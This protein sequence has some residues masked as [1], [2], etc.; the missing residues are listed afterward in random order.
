MR[1]LLL[2][3]VFG[4]IFGSCTI[5]KNIMFKTDHDYEFDVPS[6]SANIIQVLSP[7]DRLLFR[8]FSNEGARLIELTAG[9][10]EGN[11]VNAILPNFTFIIQPD[12]FVELPEVGLVEVAGLTVP[13]AQDKLEG[14]YSAFY[15]RPYALIEVVNNRVVVFPGSG[16]QGRMVTLDQPNLTVIDVLG[17][18]GGIANR[19]D[20]SKVKL[21]RRPDGGLDEVYLMDLSTIEGI[22]FANMVVQDRDVIYVEPVPEI[23]SEVLRDIS[24][25]V[26]IISGVALIYAIING[27][28]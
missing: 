15:K 2:L 6:D 9:V 10:N 28:L 25:F 5:N 4:L 20:A 26:S 1:Y 23:A 19:G 16:G 13:E 14:L 24:P 17:L 22:K 11:N 21:I 7:N 8:L 18:A 12:G 3:A 27:R